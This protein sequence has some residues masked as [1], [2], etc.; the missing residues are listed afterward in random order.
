M[1][2]ER[3]AA[4]PRT[5]DIR[6][7]AR[8]DRADL[9]KAEIEAEVANTFRSAGFEP[10]F[11]TKGATHVMMVDAAG[12][13]LLVT[14][15]PLLT[16][17]DV[18]AILN[19]RLV[20][21]TAV[22]DLWLVSSEMSDDLHES[23]NRY[24]C[25][26]LF[27]AEL[28]EEVE[29]L[30][31]YRPRELPQPRPSARTPVGRALALNADELKT[32]ATTSLLLIEDRLDVLTSERPNSP[33]GKAQRQQEIESLTTLKDQLIV[34]RDLPDQVKKGAVSEGQAN[35]S[36]KSVMEAV[37]EYWN[38]NS[39]TICGRAVT[40]ALFTSTV[41]VCKL[42]G[43]SGDFTIAVSAAMAGG[44]TVMDGLKGIAHKRFKS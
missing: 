7:L 35:K 2:R 29:R 22:R 31:R 27:R 1:V 38:K 13:R 14:A 16:I 41:L 11:P 21:S 23:R 6:K 43:A 10:L 44:K 19:S 42:A 28:R 33:E 15:L 25:R 24:G 17:D 39:E 30:S 5:A 18:E 32:A 36:V 3:K 34:I 20:N 4:R 12:Y 37:R 26:I 9:E 8:K 40:I